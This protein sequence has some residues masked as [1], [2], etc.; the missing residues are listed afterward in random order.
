MIIALFCNPLTFLFHYFTSTQKD[1]N[2]LIQL[3]V[4]LEPEA[5]GWMREKGQQ[6]LFICASH[7]TFRNVLVVPRDYNKRFIF[8]LVKLE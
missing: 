5:G 7:F 3:S 8:E 1:G 2:H 6:F 4:K